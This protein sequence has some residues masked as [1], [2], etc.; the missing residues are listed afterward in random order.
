MRENQRRGL[1]EYERMATG[2]FCLEFLI[3]GVGD[4]PCSK[5]L[6]IVSRY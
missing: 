4:T 2:A 1:R 3:S 5:L 6:L